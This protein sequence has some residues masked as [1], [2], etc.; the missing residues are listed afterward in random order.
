MILIIN[1]SGKDLEFVLDDKYKSVAVEKQSVAL[2]TETE[3]FLQESECSQVRRPSQTRHIVRRTGKR[4][5]PDS[6]VQCRTS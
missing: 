2:P 6:S 3:K 4:C 1:T 5:A